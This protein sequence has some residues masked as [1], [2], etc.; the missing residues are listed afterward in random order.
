MEPTPWQLITL[1]L[2]S[3]L[4]IPAIGVLTFTCCWMATEEMP[5]LQ[6]LSTATAVSLFSLGWFYLGFRLLRP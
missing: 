2:H 4:M 6:R 1:G 5:R 3:D